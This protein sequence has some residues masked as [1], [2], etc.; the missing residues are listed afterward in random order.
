MAVLVVGG[1]G[2]TGKEAELLTSR[3]RR[4]R[5]VQGN[6]GNPWRWQ[7]LSSPG[8]LRLGKE[9]VLVVGGSRNIRSAEVLQPSYGDNDR[10]VW[11]VLN[12]SLSQKFGK[13]FLVNFNKRILAFGKLFIK[14]ATKCK[15]HGL[16]NIHFFL[17]DDHGQCEQLSSSSNCTR[18]V[19]SCP[20]CALPKL[21]STDNLALIFRMP[22]CSYLL[23]NPSQIYRQIAVLLVFSKRKENV[24]RYY[25]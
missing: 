17:I 2:G 16:P 21:R 8:M 13:P 15:K 11:T 5:R 19:R 1:N 3:P 12:E 23:G 24:N 9:R 4:T 10:G 14:Q 25:I 7:Q 18:L 6:Q 22:R 20:R